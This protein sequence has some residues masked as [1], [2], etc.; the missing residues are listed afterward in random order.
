MR[1]LWVGEFHAE[2]QRSAETQRRECL[3]AVTAG[4]GIPRRESDGPRLLRLT[5]RPLGLGKRLPPDPWA[6]LRLCGPLRLCVK[7]AGEAEGCGFAALG[8]ARR[9]AEQVGLILRPTFVLDFRSFADSAGR[10]CP[11][12][13]RSSARP[14]PG[15]GNDRAHGPPRPSTGPI[16]PAAR[17]APFGRPGAGAMLESPACALILPGAA[18]VSNGPSDRRGARN[19]PCEPGPRRGARPFRNSRDRRWRELARAIFSFEKAEANPLGCRGAFR[20]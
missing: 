9:F 1:I 7:S 6:S 2:T 20:V 13:T 17:R 16:R 15:S 18:V 10:A 3:H 8:R 11:S 14:R 12:R 19:G 4:G 5:S